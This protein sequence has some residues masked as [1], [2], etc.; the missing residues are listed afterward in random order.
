MIKSAEHKRMKDDALIEGYFV[1]DYSEFAM[2][3]N[4]CVVTTLLEKARTISNYKEQKSIC[5]SGFQLLYSS[6]EDFA[7]LLHA[8]RNKINGENLEGVQNSVSV[9]QKLI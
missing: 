1:S 2:R 8:F 5:L 7:L 3:M 4:F 6:Y 9:N